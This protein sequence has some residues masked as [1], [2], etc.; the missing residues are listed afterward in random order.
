MKPARTA[1]RALAAALLSAACAGE[2]AP[3][4][5]EAGAPARPAT[6]RDTIRVEGM[7]EPVTL[8]LYAPSQGFPLPFTTYLPDEMT[9]EPVGGEGV[10]FEARFGG[11]PNRDAFVYLFVHPADETEDAARETVR[12][13]AE[14]Y[15]PIREF[16]EVDPAHRF[17]WSIVQFRF[18][19][20]QQGREPVVGAVGLGRHAGRLFHVIVQYPLEYGDGFPPRAQ[21]ILDRWR[22]ADGSS[23]G[24]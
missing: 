23:L 10:R 16:A 5:R 15:G 1:R 14:S 4:R 11:A 12:A 9:A 21:R 20:R 13:V 22:W 24:G 7:A 2:E 6:V 19:G 17:P 3:A 18:D 8:R